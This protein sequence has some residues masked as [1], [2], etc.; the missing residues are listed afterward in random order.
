LQWPG[1]SH[2]SDTPDYAELECMDWND[3]GVL[4]GSG[5]EIGSHT[6]THPRL[7]ELDDDTLTAELEESRRECTQHLGRSC[8]SIA[9]PFGNVDARVAARAEEAGYVSGAALS[10]SLVPQGALRWPRV[11]IYHEDASWRFRLKVSAFTRRA[12]ASRVW[13][14]VHVPEPVGPAQGP[15]TAA[16]R[17]RQ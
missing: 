12:R 7:T 11:G 4:A 9:Y 14:A 1:I 3:L 17:D 16:A 13:P 6:Q 10:H 5:W 2:W 8:D 15:I